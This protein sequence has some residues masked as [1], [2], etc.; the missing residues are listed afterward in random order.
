[1][2]CLHKNTIYL[3]E[4]WE[5]SILLSLSEVVKLPRP[6]EFSQIALGAD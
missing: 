4:I 2:L 5:H 1:M 6:D 3:Q